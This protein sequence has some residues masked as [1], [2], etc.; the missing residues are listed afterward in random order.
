M[1]KMD[2]S[3]R[4]TGVAQGKSAWNVV[5]DQLGTPPGMN[6]IIAPRCQ[7]LLGNVTLRHR[8]KAEGKQAMRG[9]S[10]LRLNETHSNSLEYR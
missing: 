8:R 10:M 5:M 9:M 3:F 7:R 1:S 2:S 6:G 4:W